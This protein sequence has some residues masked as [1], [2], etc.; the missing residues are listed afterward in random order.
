MLGREV[1]VVVGPAPVGRRGHRE[2]RPAAGADGAVWRRLIARDL[3]APGV[4][5]VGRSSPP[6]SGRRRNGQARRAT[7]TAGRSAPS[8]SPSTAT[9]PSSAARLRG[10][11]EAPIRGPRRGAT[12]AERCMA[13]QGSGVRDQAHGPGGLGGKMVACPPSSPSRSR[14][15][16]PGPGFARRSRRC[17]AQRLLDDRSSSLVCDSGPRMG[18]WRSP[19]IRRRGHRDPARGSSRTA[20]TRNLLM[21]AVR[22]RSR[23]LPDPG[24]RAGRATDW[25]AGCWPRSALAPDV[26]LAFGP[27]RPAPD[28]SVS[29]ARELN[30]WFGSFCQAG[31]P[32]IDRV[33][34]RRHATRRPR[35]FLGHLGF[36]TDANGCV[37]RAAWEQVPFRDDR[38][39]RGPPARPGHAPGRLRQGVRA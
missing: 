14:R 23:R 24:R 21:A 17:S 26:G 25:L 7:A 37:A 2:E 33:G 18:R 38:L 35:H 13:A 11:C 4:G 30:D 1:G 9:M 6:G 34:A 5:R 28:A 27:Y 32:R 31:E 20:R 8:D 22:G 39:R 10:G 29:V 3:G 36:F 12:W 15:S 19:R 16:T